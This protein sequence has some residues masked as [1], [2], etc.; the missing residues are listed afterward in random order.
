MMLSD[1]DKS[2]K[3]FDELT[4]QFA[5]E[6][7]ESDTRNKLIDPIFKECLGWNEED[8]NRETYVRPGYLDYVFSIDNVRR[9]VLEAKREGELFNIPSSYSGRYYK[10]GGVIWNDMKIRKAI[11][12]AQQYCVNSGVHYGIISNGKQYLIFEGFKRSKDWKEGNC[13]VFHSFEDIRKNYG[14]F[15]DM[16]NK[17]SVKYGSLRQLVS[18]ESFEVKYLSRPIDHLHARSSTVTRNNLSPFLQPIIDY[19]FT[20]IIDESQLDLLKNCYVYRRQ[21]Q[22]AVAEISR[23]F[24]TVPEFAKKYRMEDIIES[25]E[26][27]GKFQDTYQEL[28]RLARSAAQK[29]YLI[30]LMGGIGSGKTTFIHHFFTVMKPEKTLWFYVDF[31]KV[32]EDPSKIEEYILRIIMEEFDKKYKSDFISELSS[33]KI[34]TLKSE[35]RDVKALFS[36]LALKG[37]TLSLV[38]DNV[39]QHSYINAK[40]QEQALLIAKRLT[41]YLC[42]I[43]ILTLR[44][45]SFFKSTMSGVLDAFPAQTFHISS[46]SFEDLIRAR[47]EYV[48][49]LLEKSDDEIGEILG[50]PIAIS[51]SRDVV[52]TFFRIVETS[53]RSSRRVGR[54]ILRFV[55][56]ISGGDMRTAL[57]FFRTF[58][59]SGNTDVDEMLRRPLY[60]IPFHHVIKSI[61]L[62]H[63]RLYR[64]TSSKIMN[65][66]DFNPAHGKSHFLNLR[67]LNYLNNRLSYRPTQG[68]GFIGID[69]ILDEG[70]RIGLNNLAIADALITMARF[71]LVQF[72]NQSKEGYESADYVRITNAGI[73]YLKYLITKFIYLDLVWVDTPITDNN[74]VDELL[75]HIVETRHP[76]L[77]E[78]LDERFLRTEIFLGYLESAERNELAD[79]AE[80]RDSDLTR[81]EFMPKIRQS[82]EKEKTYIQSKRTIDNES[83]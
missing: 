55:K 1:C 66:F 59:V 77:P 11:E 28:E 23:H 41:D 50:N 26:K 58:L 21:Y 60:Q 6:L 56:E 15:W 76:K 12:Q 14:L 16:L 72:E 43:T 5:K 36:F 73:Y 44:E 82:Y 54:E 57:Y 67:I 20:D 4:K 79:H 35:I 33:L 70:D 71:G 78:D 69:D 62:E 46:P 29:G 24:D 19:V 68:R 30:L 39:D 18:K 31:L 17:K 25:A 3:R 81:V 42:T 49:R 83:A 63:S 65:I 22:E 34:D 53:L 80:F 40:Y 32:T 37:Y 48:I 64:M 45:E 7:T 75:K 13:I 52:K 38:L 74:V 2:L 51:V 9:F 47:I 61:I 8:I 10:I 27:A